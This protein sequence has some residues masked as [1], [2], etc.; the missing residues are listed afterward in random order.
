MKD[1]TSTSINNDSVTLQL[2]QLMKK[3]E[4]LS[5]QSSSSSSS[6][7]DEESIKKLTTTTDSKNNGSSSLLKLPSTYYSSTTTTTNSSFEYTNDEIN[8][9]QQVYNKLKN[10]NDNTILNNYC[11]TM[12][13]L[14][15]L[16]LTT[17]VCKL[18]IEESIEKYKKFCMAIKTCNVHSLSFIDEITNIDDDTNTTTTTTTT[19]TNNNNDIFTDTNVMKQ[20]QS[21]APCGTDYN[22]RSIMWIKG[23]GNGILPTEETYSIQAGILYWLAIHADDTSIHDGITF[24]IDTSSSNNNSRT[25]HGNE[26]KIQKVHQSYPMRPKCIQIAGA[27]KFTRLTINALIKVASMFTKQKILQRIE[28][29]TV[30]DAFDSIPKQSAPK[31]LGGNGGNIDNVEQWVKERIMSFPIPNIVR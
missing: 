23:K 15:V 17:I 10:D 19:T 2:N 16:A 13:S 6:T 3:T 30:Q 4:Q 7:K 27:N 24:I 11:P 18:R 5:L 22:N 31:Y 9:I 1:S 29:V 8:T 28:F 25:K 21:Y 26:S 12:I 20:F 14:R